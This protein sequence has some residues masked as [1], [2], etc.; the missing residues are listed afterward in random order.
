MGPGGGAL[1]VIHERPA[2]GEAHE[3]L[4]FERAL[5]WLRLAAIV[6]IVVLAAGAR[7][8]SVLLVPAAVT[9]I[10]GTVATQRLTL[11]DGLPLESIR[12]QATVFLLADVVAVYLTGTAF[13]AETSWMAFYFYPLLSLEATVV[14]GMGAGVA[15]TAASIV[16]YGLQL[17]I[18]V[19]Y[20]NP[21][22]PRSIAGAVGI[23]A[24]TGGLMAGSAVVADRGRRDLRAL[25][26][27][28]AA[29]AQQQQE[30][31]TLEL[32]DRRLHEAVG[33]RVRSVALRDPDGN[34][35]LVRW[36]SPERR[37]LDRD[38]VE[39]TMG[40]IEVLTRR[41]TSGA[42]L[43][44]QVDGGSP[45]AAALGV[46]DWVRG[47]TLVP[48]FLEGQWVGILPVLWPAPTVP[49]DG[50]L[51][52]LYGLASQMGLSLA[53]GELQ[54]IRAEAATDSLTQLLN[55][56]AISDELA[57]Y[58]AR[59]R[60]SGSRMAVLFCDLDGFKAVNDVH[61]HEAGDAVLR[62]VGIAVRGAIR[63]GDVVGRY[64]GDELLVVAADAGAEDAVL[65][66]QRVRRAVVDVAGDQGVDVTV[67]IAVYP[68]DGDTGADL[69]VAA[70][71]AMYRGK[72]RGAGNVMVAGEAR[73]RGVSAS[74]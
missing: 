29:L 52:L 17:G 50:Q 43:T 49:A 59:A 47:I 24:L 63:Q 53:Q 1:P 15:V 41:F 36:H 27:L 58:V 72:L 44:Y 54:R 16:A 46:P 45:I 57:A 30:T 35:L 55:R 2:I 38:A 61:G 9:I 34:F 8:T 42:S 14:G 66:A 69:M 12:R 31:E 74:A 5:L 64:G 67:G 21:T 68:V 10:A 70:D 73:P 22:P 13:A 18:H 11:R 25:L 39:A 33:G 65:L 4:G 19:S 62:A 48:I 7:L 60:R 28:T 40:P 20:G 6:T 71:Q 32:L 26:D 3:L 23:I 51:R 37:R 56:R